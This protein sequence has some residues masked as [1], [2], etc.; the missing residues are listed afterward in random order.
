M[1]EEAVSPHAL[2]LEQLRSSAAPA[3]ADEGAGRWLKAEDPA[4]RPAENFPLLRL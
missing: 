4:R 2:A 1:D 3:G